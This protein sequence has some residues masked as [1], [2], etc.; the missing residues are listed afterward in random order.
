MQNESRAKLKRFGDVIPNR[1]DK[2]SRSKGKK[3]E[4]A[5]ILYFNQGLARYKKSVLKTNCRKK[6]DLHTAGD[7]DY[8]GTYSS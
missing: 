3:G 1:N 5:S 7:I 2:P 4:K 6:N 8:L